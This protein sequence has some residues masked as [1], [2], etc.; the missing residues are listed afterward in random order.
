M[1]KVFSLYD[2]KYQ[3]DITPLCKTVTLSGDTSQC[4]RKFDL[5]IVYSV[6]D[7]NMPHSQ[8]GCATKVW[9]IDDIKGEIFRGVVF[10][11]ELNSDNYVKVTAYDYLIYFLKSKASFNFTNTTPENITKKVCQEVGVTPGNLAYTGIKINLV[12]QG[13]TLYDIIMKAYT[14]AS[15]LNGKQYIPVMRGMLLDIVEKGGT[16]NTLIL[17]TESNIQ[18]SSY[19]DSISDMINR[20]KIYDKDGNY[21]STVSNSSWSGSCGILQ[22]VY[23][24]EDDK[25]PY[26]VANN[27]LHG[28]DNYFKVDITGDLGCKTGNA[29]YVR[30]PW[31]NTTKDSAKMYIDA[32]THTWDL[33]SGIYNTELTLNFSNKMDLKG[34]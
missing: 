1:I 28:V 21:I 34:V 18:N 8:I 9:A 19:T 24:K 25:N 11:R 29:V 2:G 26:T 27:M 6:Y 10:D 32:D 14:Q 17:D 7:K 16:V 23:T 30:I 4:A 20:V 12:V 3:T 31:L 22:D 13:E 33:A 5:D 15:K